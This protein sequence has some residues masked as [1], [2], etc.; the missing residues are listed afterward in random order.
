M[1]LIIKKDYF[2]EKETKC[3]EKAVVGE[4]TAFSIRSDMLKV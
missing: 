4:T 2:L 1:I 3:P